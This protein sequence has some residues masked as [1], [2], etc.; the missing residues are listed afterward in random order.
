MY[1]EVIARLRTF[2]ERLKSLKDTVNVESNSARIH[3][4][5]AKMAEPR[6][7]DDNDAAQQVIA[8]VK[9]LKSETDPVIELAD[10]AA[11]ILELAELGEAENDTATLAET[12]REAETIAT[13]L[14][15]LEVKAT[16]NEPHDNAG[17]FVSIHAG[18]GGTES[19][20][21]AAMLERMYL[22]FC[23]QQGFSVEM[24]EKVPGEE[25]GIRGVTYLIK[26]AYIYGLLKAEVGVHRLVRISPFDA[27]GRRHTSFVAVDVTPELPDTSK[28]IEIN[29]SDLRV[30]R[31]RAGGA[32]GQ[33]VNKTDSAVRITHLPTG[34]V[35][36][37]Q[38][39]RSQHSNRAT[40]MKMLRARLLREEE[41]K[42]DQE[43][44]KLYGE[45]GEIAFGA[46]IRSYT[47]QPRA[48]VKDHRTGFEMG[49][50]SAVLDGEIMGFI[51]AYLRQRRRRLGGQ[52]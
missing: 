13:A 19:C 35:A 16:L 6:F 50:A 26:G 25:A 37:C 12:Q 15:E 49:N 11:E 52:R 20:D 2:D 18:A 10:R 29:E 48:L 28:E 46:Q 21:W 31:Y 30:D 8:E 3:E 42:R 51:D 5:E 32:G 17:A 34:I 44:A 45:K 38:N 41:I 1:S 4:F 36:Q 7:W 14:D 23:E 39:E 27:K 40:A 22:R 47:L 24:I 43:L 9:K 33:H